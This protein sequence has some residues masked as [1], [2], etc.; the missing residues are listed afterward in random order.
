MTISPE[1]NNPDQNSPRTRNNLLDNTSLVPS[2]EGYFKG[3]WTFRK[4][5]E[6]DFR[7]LGFKSHKFSHKKEPETRAADSLWLS[8]NSDS[9]KLAVRNPAVTDIEI[10]VTF[11]GYSEGGLSGYSTTVTVTHDGRNGGCIARRMGHATF[12]TGM[13]DSRDVMAHVQH[14]LAK[15]SIR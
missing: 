9:K 14:L 12:V 6:A 11:D 1:N 15:P 13:S 3:N 10:R 8:W 7:A 2:P 5:L 4:Q